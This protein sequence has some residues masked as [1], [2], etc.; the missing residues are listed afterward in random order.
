MRPRPNTNFLAA[1]PESLA[2]EVRELIEEGRLAERLLQKYPSSHAVRTDRAL[3]DYAMQIKQG[4][5]RNAG[6]LNRVAYDGSLQT[7]KR[8][9][10][11]HS[12]ISR[13][14]GAR[15]K[16]S[17]EI[18]I[19][20]VFRPMP[21]EFLR[22]IVVHELAHLKEQEHDKAFYQLC[23]HMEPDYHRLEFDL[24][25]YLTY[26]DAGGEALWRGYSSV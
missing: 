20:S 21:P 17:R 16:S 10:G 4:Y 19:A 13:V 2:Q 11:M 1:Y 5:L 9:L 18:R 12:G 3:Y 23:I 26:L 22:M 7:M 6:P 8:A 15:L 24:R 25:A 14:Q